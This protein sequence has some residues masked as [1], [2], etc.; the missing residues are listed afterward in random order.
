MFHKL[1]TT[2]FTPANL[3]TVDSN[4][5]ISIGD[6]WKVMMPRDFLAAHPERRLP[7]CWPWIM[8][9][10]WKEAESEMKRTT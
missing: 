6:V 5:F 10:E 3:K 4:V 8:G 7:K 9:I 2:F 1:K